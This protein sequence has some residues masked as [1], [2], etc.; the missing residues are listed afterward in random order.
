MYLGDLFFTPSTKYLQYITIN[1]QDRFHIHNIFFSIKYSKKSNDWRILTYFNHHLA[2]TCVYWLISR[3]YLY[4]C[5]NLNPHI[6]KVV[7]RHRCW[8]YFNLSSNYHLT[9]QFKCRLEWVKYIQ[10]VYGS[11]FITLCNKTPST[12]RLQYVPNIIQDRFPMIYPFSII[13]YSKNRGIFVF[14][15]NYHSTLYVSTC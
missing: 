7:S 14:T 2:S 10:H 9:K 1:I 8:L 3:V 4:L 12:I 6:M 15:L 11:L 5:K 13:R